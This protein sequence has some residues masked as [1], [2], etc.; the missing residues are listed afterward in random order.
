MVEIQCRHG[1]VAIHKKVDDP[2]KYVHKC[3]HRFTYMKCYNKVVIPIN[4]KNKWPKTN[5]PIIL[6]PM[7]KHRPRRPKKLH[8]SEP[9]ET[10]QTKW[11]RT[12]T[13]HMCNTCLEYEHNSR[14]CKK[15]KQLIYFKGNATFF[16]EPV[17][18]PT[19]LQLSKKNRRKWLV[20]LLKPSFIL[21]IYLLK[22]AC[23]C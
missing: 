2:I 19:Q 5:D 4:G 12:N 6:P 1:V 18:P 7:F 16:S 9:D 23:V 8:R 14:T 15:D 22:I 10:N 3:Y 11:Q 17:A 13:S 21:G 20:I